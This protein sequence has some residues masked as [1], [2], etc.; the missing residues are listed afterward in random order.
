MRKIILSSGTTVA[1]IAL[2]PLVASA[3]DLSRVTSLLSALVNYAI[4]LAVGVAVLAFFYGLI[5]YMYSSKGGEDAKKNYQ[6]MVYG[7]IAI[8]VML[9]VFGIVKLLQNTFGVGSQT[10]IPP[11]S[12]GDIRVVGN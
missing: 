1:L 12:I 9:S 2:T 5:K 10:Q 8:F 11:P 4:G 6:I 7:V 3:Q